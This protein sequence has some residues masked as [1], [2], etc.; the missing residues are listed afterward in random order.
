MIGRMIRFFGFWRDN[1]TCPHCGEYHPRGFPQ[2]AYGGIFYQYCHKC[3]AAF[4]WPYRA[5]D[6]QYEKDVFVHIDSFKRYAEKMHLARN[7]KIVDKNGHLL[8]DR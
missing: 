7:A 3:G 2:C 6:R 1:F 5:E 8:M 4:I